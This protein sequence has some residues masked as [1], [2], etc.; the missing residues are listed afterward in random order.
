MR[1]RDHNVRRAVGDADK[2]RREQGEAN[3]G[4]RAGREGLTTKEVARVGSVDVTQDSDDLGLSN[5]K[6][7][8]VSNSTGPS[9]GS[10]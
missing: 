3:A 9:R 2:M 10:P 1:R 4:R 7:I 8:I 5:L 6:H